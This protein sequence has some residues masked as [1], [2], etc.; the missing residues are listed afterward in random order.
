V[1]CLLPLILSDNHAELGM[2]Q[3][4]ASSTTKEL[5]DEDAGVGDDDHSGD[6]AAQVERSR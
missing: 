6:G 3:Q 1:L 4:L 5:G 2:A